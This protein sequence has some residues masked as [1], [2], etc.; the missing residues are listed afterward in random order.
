M[1]THTNTNVYRVVRLEILVLQRQTMR[2]ALCWRSCYHTRYL[3][4]YIYIY[5]HTMRRVWPCMSCKWASVHDTYTHTHTYI[6][7]YIN[8]YI[9]ITP[10]VVP[11]YSC[12]ANG[13]DAPVLCAE[14]HAHMYIRI[15]I[16]ICIYVYMYAHT[17]R[18]ADFLGCVS[19]SASATSRSRLW[20]RQCCGHAAAG[21]PY[22][23]KRGNCTPRGLARW[24]AGVCWRHSWGLSVDARM[25]VLANDPCL[26][27]YLY[28]YIYIY[29][30]M[31][32]SDIIAA[33][34]ALCLWSLYVD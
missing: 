7:I 9:Y 13:N 34:A 32:I 3:H 30:H 14:A 15:Y 31:C 19:K 33:I 1:H 4:M 24:D 17:V 28:I 6:Y 5:T 27:V 21:G 11:R 8:I 10:W 23:R 16:Y 18:R 25:I 20:P 29:I 2:R 26:C 22:C 12:V